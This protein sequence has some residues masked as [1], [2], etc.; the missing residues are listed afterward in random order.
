MPRPLVSVAL[1]VKN[2]L[3]HLKDAIA[4]L[5]RQTYVAITLVVQD[6]ASTDGSLDYL[7]SLETPFPVD[8]VSAPDRSLVAG[9]NRAL[10]RCTGDLVV[11]AACDEVLDDDAIARYVH[12]YHE[13]P[14]ALFIYSGMRLDDGGGAPLRE[15]QP[16]PFDFVDF[17]RHRDRIVPPMSGAFNRRLLGAELRF[18]ETL[19][20]VPD[21]ELLTRL[22]LRFGPH[23][24]ISQPGMTAT[25]RADA[26]SMTYRPDAYRQIALDKTRIIN[27]IL[28]RGGVSRWFGRGL[29]QDFADYLQRD[30]L[31]DMHL[32]FARHIFGI[33]GDCPEFR[34]QVLAAASYMSEKPTIAHEAR[35]SR[36]FIID[37]RTQALTLRP[38]VPPASPPENLSEVVATMPLDSIRVEPEWA[39]P[40]STQDVR[41]ALNV[42][43]TSAAPWSYSAWAQ[44]DLPD[45]ARDRY[46]YWLRIRVSRAS[47]SPLL[48]LYD[49]TRNTI[50]SEIPVLASEVPR[51]YFLELS[52]DV[53]RG[54]LFRN[55]PSP[56][57]SVVAFAGLHLVQMPIAIE[58]AA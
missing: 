19:T 32:S 37:P 10:Q 52:D 26:S 38:H 34:E 49:S 41:Q 5:C 3:P 33:G 27:Q 55:G 25:A 15:Y 21:F 14:D 18:D 50:R 53:H 40:G 44:P 13:H 45:L 54:L 11:A 47:G 31:S 28:V 39:S 1:P 43:T 7:R 2:G 48:S 36:H 20:T 4:G 29:P 12:W 56:E 9:Y 6:S 42:V 57:K 8:L 16:L 24:I 30:V 17:L 22:A 23:R 51:D 58:Q 46:W 35:Q